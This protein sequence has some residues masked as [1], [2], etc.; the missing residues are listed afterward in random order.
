L[1]EAFQVASAAYPFDQQRPGF[2][3]HRLDHDS[4]ALRRNLGRMPIA[5][6]TLRAAQSSYI[7]TGLKPW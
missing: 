5:L 2:T 4:T 7:L 6:A 3:P 1:L